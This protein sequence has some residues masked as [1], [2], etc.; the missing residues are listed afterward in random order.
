MPQIQDFFEIL[1]NIERRLDILE[2]T[3]GGAISTGGSGGGA[4][5]SVNGKTGVVVL[6]QDDILDG[7]TNK[8]YSATEQTKLAGIEAGA[9][10][11]VGE[12]Y[13]TAEKSKLSGIEAGATADQSDAEIETAYN[14]QVAVATQAEAEAG[15]STVVKRFTPE[16]IKYAISALASSNLGDYMFAV[17]ASGDQSVGA[18]SFT[19]MTFDTV[20]A[21]PQ[22]AFDNANDWYEIPKSGWWLIT[23]KYRV[24]NGTTTNLGIGAG[25][26]IGDNVGNRWMN[27]SSSRTTMHYTYLEHFDEGDSVL[28]WCR[29]DSAITVRAGR[30][31]QGFLVKED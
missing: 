30:I 6:D 11:N 5:D 14:N 4:V 23:V 10:V 19:K 17:S 3:G 22:S 13:T 16:L 12:E 1:A 15:T 7:T 20:D 2:R 18:G 28:S 27:G 9:E 8:Q 25:T 21:D 26:T 31:F 29:G 24:P